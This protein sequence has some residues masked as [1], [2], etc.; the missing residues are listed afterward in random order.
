METGPFSVSLT[1]GPRAKLGQNAP[2]VDMILLS[3]DSV[4]FYTCET[5]L[6]S[7]STN[8]FRNLLPFPTQHGDG[9]INPSERIL[10]LPEI[11][12]SELE[13]ILLAIHNIPR[14]SASNSLFDVNTLTRAIDRLPEYGIS[15]DARIT[16]TSQIYHLMLS[17]APVHPLEVY[18][19]AAQYEIHSLAV[20]VSSHTLGL[21]LSEVSAELSRRI[22]SVYLL[23]LFQLHMGRTAEL[24]DLLATEVGLHNPTAVCNFANQRK[25]KDMWNFAVAS[26]MFFIKPDMTTGAIREMVMEHTSELTCP[27]CL[28]L[29][30]SLLNRVIA[31]WS[32]ARR[33]I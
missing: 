21:D 13:I 16:P 18:A 29:R 15:P 7:V 30:D 6:L 5:T 17:C 20:T 1:F 8:S 31:E 33:T 4:V 10:T 14:K 23:R 32:L 2:P 12:S 11:P 25:L 24:K 9:S 22:G 3:N 27:D 28:K 19:L 26:L